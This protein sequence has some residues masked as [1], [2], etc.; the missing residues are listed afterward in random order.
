M[1]GII[2]YLGARAAQPLL[3][4]GLERLE[5]RGYDSAGLSV[6]DADGAIESVRAVGNLAELRD[7]VARAWP[8]EAEATVGIAHTR[9][10]THGG[11][12]AEN[13]HPHTSCD[14]DT[15][16]VLNG[17]V[18]N[19]ETL[20]EELRAGGCRFT[21]ETDAEVVA[22]LVSHELRSGVTLS[23]AARRAYLRLEGHYAFLVMTASEPEVLVAARKECPMV[24]GLGADET[25]IASAVAAFPSEIS[26]VLVVEDDEIVTCR[27]EGF[28]IMTK[29][30]EPV[31]RDAERVTRD[32]ST[33]SMGDHSSFMAKEIFEQ[34]AALERTIRGLGLG[35]L[36]RG[37]VSDHELAE[38]SRI[39]IVACGTS[40]HAGMLGAR[41]IERWA[42][43]PVSVAVASE[44]R[45]QEPILTP[46]E[47]VIGVSQSG[48]T[49][50]TLAALKLARDLGAPTVAVTN[51]ADSQATRDADSVVLTQAGLEVGVAATKT[52][53][54]QVAA[55]AL[56][57]LRLSEI[58]RTLGRDE[59]AELVSE[60]RRLPGLVT[61]TIA[62]TSDVVF[63]V[64]SEW[65]DEEF[66]MYLGRDLAYPVALE[67]AL[68]MKEISY[69]PSDAYPAGE[70]KHG[71]IALLSEG[72]PVVC[73][74]TDGVVMEKLLSNVA[75]VRARGAAVLA[76]ASAGQHRVR[77][78]ADA[79]CWLPPVHPDL[80]PMLAS[81]PLQ[82]LALGVA[83]AR[84][85]NVD[86]PRNLAKT[87]TVE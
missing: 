51:V 68:K 24:I 81:V 12:T 62:T 41:L 45:Y 15:Y 69:A 7:A 37:M 52:F 14:A 28:A 83:E 40:Y 13:A 5:Y 17:I 54:T 47:V 6:C 77:D 80:Q 22:H 73:V 29:T 67:G 86:Q 70:M 16:I 18:E 55:F 63:D 61:E 56:L 20:R 53:T 48:E 78:L 4:D 42:K 32:L 2:G 46:G 76:V 64:A 33:V 66:F 44:W 8:A 21:S 87:V 35:A 11:V 84:G 59:R 85:L 23:E 60:L 25:F 82:M 38:A 19:Y 27:R 71:P 50:D 3:L 57:A 30:S 34:A 72:T 79:I 26:D 65:A 31:M 10:A 58:R 74:A 43:L 75:E 36:L 9:W 49:R 1:C 39:T